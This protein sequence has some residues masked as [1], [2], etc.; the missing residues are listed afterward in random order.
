[1]IMSYQDAQDTAF[2]MVG[3]ERDRQDKK[4]GKQDHEPDR[5]LRILVE[6]VG[7]VARAIDENKPEDY[8]TELIQVAAV[9]IAAVETEYRAKFLRQEVEEYNTLIRDMKR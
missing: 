9:A 5:W 2:E 8:I 3:K 6:E 7:E 1:M 4:W